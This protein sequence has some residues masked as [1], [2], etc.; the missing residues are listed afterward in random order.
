MEEDSTFSGDSDTESI[1]GSDE[2]WDSIARSIEDVRPNWEP[3]NDTDI[4]G[5]DF[6]PDS[7]RHHTE[8]VSSPDSEDNIGS[9]SG[10]NE[11][12]GLFF[13]SNGDTGSILRPNGDPGTDPV[14][15]GTMLREHHHA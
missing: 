4:L 14:R 1:P 13:Q 7:L 12:T 8:P 11:N 6:D 15:D 9:T 10:A 5:I 3:I 2:L